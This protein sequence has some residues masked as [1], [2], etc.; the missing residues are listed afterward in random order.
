MARKIKRKLRR[1]D[2]LNEQDE[3]LSF[4]EEAA[5]WSK[6]NWPLLLIASGAVAVV[7]VVFI[8]IK[9]TLSDS[10]TRS[11]AQVADALDSYSKSSRNEIMAIVNPEEGTTTDPAKSFEDTAY[12]I[13]KVMKDQSGEK[14]NQAVMFYLANSY[15]KSGGYGKARETYQKIIN[16]KSKDAGLIDLS[17]YNLAMSYYLEKKYGDALPIFDKLVTGKTPTARAGSLVYAGRCYEQT[18]KLDKAVE[19]YQLALDAY[20]DSKL[21][22]GLAS[23]IEKLKMQK[24]GGGV[25]GTTPEEA[26]K[27]ETMTPEKSVP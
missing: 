21:T 13:D 9:S 11:Q 12:K 15:L 1:K 22:S 19:Y 27:P 23:K 10:R 5:E 20:S 17:N 14:N 6:K 7:I 26:P 16:Q 25:G 2:L 18:G 24:E 8:L 4:S 3:F